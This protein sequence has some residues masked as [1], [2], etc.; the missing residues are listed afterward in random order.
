MSAEEQMRSGAD[1][2]AAAASKPAAAHGAE[3]P[4]HEPPQVSRGSLMTLVLLALVVAAI[5]AVFGIVR[6]KHAHTALE[7][8]TDTNAA[9]PVSVE[10]PVMQQ[11]A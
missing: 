11:S 4:K 2:D 6:R 7:K 9:P 3:Q 8:Y 10:Q 1:R 5:V